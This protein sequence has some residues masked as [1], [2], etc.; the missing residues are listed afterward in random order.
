MAGLAGAT[1]SVGGALAGSAGGGTDGAT[2]LALSRLKALRSG[3]GLYLSGP[4]FFPRGP[5]VLSS[6]LRGFVAPAA[7]N[8]CGGGGPRPFV[9]SFG[10]GDDAVSCAIARLRREQGRVVPR[11]HL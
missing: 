6:A 2:E 10:A 9:M 11:A 8:P 1:L 7:S 4:G 5:A 3:G